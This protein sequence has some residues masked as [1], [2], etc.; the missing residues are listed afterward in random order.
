MVDG[1]MRPAILGARRHGQDAVSNRHG[2]IRL[3]DV[4]VVGMAGVNHRHLRVRLQQFVQPT[5]V[6]RI[7]VLYDHQREPRPGRQSGDE[8]R[9]GV[10]AAGR[11]PRRPRREMDARRPQ[12]S[13]ECGPQAVL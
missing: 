9:E 12:P 3:N 1:I 13:G 2:G 6:G 5:L 11:G 10:E 7:E 8:V 4:D